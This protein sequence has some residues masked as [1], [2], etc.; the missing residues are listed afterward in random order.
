[1]TTVDFDSVQMTKTQTAA[2]YFLL[3]ERGGCNFSTKIKNA[4]GVGAHALIVSDFKDAKTT[5][6]NSHHA[7]D[8]GL[9]GKIGENHNSN[10][11]KEDGVL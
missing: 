5:T 11:S 4:M 6:T 7:G 9:L 2:G 10:T 8:G 1:M 3:V